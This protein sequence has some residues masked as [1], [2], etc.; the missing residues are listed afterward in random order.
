MKICRQCYSPFCR[1]DCGG[2]GP[3]ADCYEQAFAED[4]M[5]DFDKWFVIVWGLCFLSIMFAALAIGY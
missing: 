1:R 3:S 5:D 2:Y 4:R